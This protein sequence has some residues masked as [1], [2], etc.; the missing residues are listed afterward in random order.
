MIK[1][2]FQLTPPIKAPCRN[3]VI[4]P[5]QNIPSKKLAT[6]KINQPVTLDLRD[7]SC[8]AVTVLLLSDPEKRKKELTRL[9]FETD[10]KDGMFMKK[11]SKVF[12]RIGIIH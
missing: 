10:Y 1:C 2:L 7:N 5:F 12:R 8:K 6:G 3:V 4:I 9:E 11:Q